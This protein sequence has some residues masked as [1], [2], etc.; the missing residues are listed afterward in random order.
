M[1]IKS[2]LLGSAAVLVA[3][4]G[5]RAADAIVAEPEPVEYVRVCDA[6]GSGW[7]YIPGTETCLKFDGDVRVQYGVKH[8]HDEDAVDEET[9]LHEANYRARLNVRASNETEYGTLNSRIR[10]VAASEEGGHNDVLSDAEGPSSAG[11]VVDWAV[12]SLAGFRI[13]FADTYWSTNNGYGYYQARFDGPYGYTNGIFFDYTAKLGEG[14]AVTVGIEDGAISGESGAPD[15]YAGFNYSANNL[16]VAGTVY[17]DSSAEA[18][19]W[20]VSAD[21]SMDSFGIGGWYMADDGDTDYVKGHAFGIRSSY[22]LAENM[23][24]FAGYGQYADQFEDGDE[25][26]FDTYTV[27]LAW[28]PVSGLL[29]Q[30]EWTS[31]SYEDTDENANFGRFS[32]RIVRSF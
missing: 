15:L 10:F 7:F 29:V 32:L 20:K 28:N 22:Q 4:T 8:Y 17:N 1:T 31:N 6:Y 24:L 26:S 14:F 27:G 9:S 21:Y 30:P 16:T 23:L 19:A 11:T 5:A 13:G 2:L 12:I 18:I 25:D 3:A